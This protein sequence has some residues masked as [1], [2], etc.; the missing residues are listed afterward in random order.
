MGFCWLTHFA[1][2]FHCV[3]VRT[4]TKSCAILCCYA[5][6]YVVFFLSFSVYLLMSRSS[7]RVNNRFSL[8]KYWQT[9]RA[10]CRTWEQKKRVA[11]WMARWNVLPSHKTLLRCI[12]PLSENLFQ[13]SEITL[14]SRYNIFEILWL[15]SV[16]ISLVASKTEPTKK[17]MA[18]CSICWH[19][20]IFVNWNSCK[21]K[22]LSDASRERERE[23]DRVYG[24]RHTK[25][26]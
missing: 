26:F 25:W 17:K 20:T 24:K 8:N 10:N 15:D 19:R 16:C 9:V 2:E 18:G 22:S 14:S 23:R 13:P 5:L 3:S 11:A 1:A 4:T 21:I 6:C 7:T 12:F